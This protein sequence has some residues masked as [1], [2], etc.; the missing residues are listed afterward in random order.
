MRKP[1]RR[2]RRIPMPAPEAAMRA[3]AARRDRAS[4]RKPFALT[5]TEASA[6]RSGGFAGPKCALHR[7]FTVP[8]N[9]TIVGAAF[10]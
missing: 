7:A 2:I 1:C 6:P 5:G 10:P 3:R 4:Q 8:A 9:L